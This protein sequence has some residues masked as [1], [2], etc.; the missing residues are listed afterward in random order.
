[1]LSATP[2]NNRMNDLKNQI[3]FITEG[4]DDALHGHGIAS[5]EQTLRK[6][7][8]RFNHWLRRDADEP[9]HRRPARSPELR[10]LQA[11]RPAD[12]CPLPQ[13]HRE[14]LRSRRDR[15]VSRSALKPINIKADIDTQD[16]FPE[17]KEI[18]REI[19]RLNL[20]AYAPAQ[21]RPAREARGV[22]PQIRP[23]GSGRI[24]L[25]ADR[26]RGEPDPPDAGEPAQAHGKLDQ[27]L[28]PDRRAPSGPGPRRS[29]SASTPTRTPRSRSSTSRTSRSRTTPSI[30]T[31]SAARSR[32]C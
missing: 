24:G 32:C 10:L 8:I 18:N 14:V 25:Q 1:M 13:A 21:V 5:I 4:R 26:P 19:R 17:L 9:H 23:P 28:R 7:Q 2:V 15:P 3:A 30:P 6:A 12:H 16:R 31:W 29:S 27:L 11:A 20:S 22:Q